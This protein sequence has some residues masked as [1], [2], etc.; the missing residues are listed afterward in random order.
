ML[1]TFGARPGVR[2]GFAYAALFLALGASL[3][4]L[5]VWL[6][7]RGLSGEQVGVAVAAGMI[8]RFIAAPLIG[9]FTDRFWRPRRVLTTL[10]ILLIGAFALHA[11]ARGM[12]ALTLVVALASA[13]HG[14]I[15]PLLESVA[16][17]VSRASGFAYGPVRSVG[18]AA[19][20]AANLI[21]G[22]LIANYGS[23]SVVWWLIGVSLMIAV[24]MA[25]SPA[26]P[27]DMASPTSR[28]APAAALLRRDI[29][30]AM[31]A[32]ALIQGSH[33]FYY[34][35][36]ALVW[37][38][39]GLSGAAI[40]FLWAFGVAAEIVFLTVF[41]RSAERM[42]PA[43]LFAIGA[44]GAIVRWSAMAF[45]PGLAWLLPL[46][47]LH[48]ATFAVAHLGFVV[49]V[50]RSAPPEAAATAQSVNAALTLGGVLAGATAVSGYLFERVGAQG[51][52]AMA[53]L[54]ALGLVASGLLWRVQ[55]SAAN[56][57]SA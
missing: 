3:P 53:I 17:R 25:A 24:A 11:P 5:P 50:A 42:G 12:L 39:A 36:S 29:L 20:I 44:L 30:L 41:G 16:I 28:S 52:A 19:F 47:T 32:S 13:F 37:A 55:A 23:E 51:Y 26:A 27:H 40:G 54:A 14:P 18:S 43:A 21:V 1:S 49:F 48:A 15:T 33:G 31:T 22:A 4:Y 2:L 10:A 9:Y 57:K 8:A 6:D 56:D 46:Q 38:D 45:E 35:F 34:G 7:G